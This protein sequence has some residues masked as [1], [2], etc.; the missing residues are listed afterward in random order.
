M[1][2]LQLVGTHGYSRSP[3]PALVHSPGLSQQPASPRRL[4]LLMPGVRGFSPSLVRPSFHFPCFFY[5]GP[6]FPLLPHYF[7]P[8]QQPGLHP[9]RDW[10]VIWVISCIL[11][12]PINSIFLL[13]PA[14]A[15]HARSAIPPLVWI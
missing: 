5:A 9:Y 3:L 11:G 8:T 1:V 14:Q 6:A 10:L 2:V 4:T 12:R 13:L 7:F 15:S